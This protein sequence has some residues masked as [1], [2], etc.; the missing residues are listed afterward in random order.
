[1]KAKNKM[2][3]KVRLIPLPGRRGFCA[4][5]PQCG[6]K[7]AVVITSVNRKDSAAAGV[8]DSCDFWGMMVI[9]TDERANP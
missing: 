4:D 8:C 5:C 6:A 1:M 9:E 2:P 3:P 7:K